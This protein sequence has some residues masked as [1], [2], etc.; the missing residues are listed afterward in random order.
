MLR[1][2]ALAIALQLV[3]PASIVI[4]LWRRQPTGRVDWLMNVLGVLSIVVALAVIAPWLMVPWQLGYGYIAGALAAGA[5][6]FQSARGIEPRHQRGGDI[7]RVGAGLIAAVAVGSSGFAMAGRYLPGTEVVDVTCPFTSGVYLVVNGGSQSLV[8]AHMATLE[9]RPR[10][11]PWRGQSYGVDLVRI[12]G[13]G[14]RA[15]GF[16]SED[17]TDYFIHGQ[18]V[19]APCGGTVLSAVSDRPDMPAGTRD[20]DRSKLAGNHVLISCNGAE[21]LVAHLLRGSVRVGIGSDVK[22]GDPLGLVG[23]SGNTDEPHVHLSAQRRSE[24]QALIGGLPVWLRID[25]RFLVRN[26]RLFCGA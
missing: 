15:S 20:S 13:F 21:V 8:N 12:D 18:P 22:V 17:P 24:G 26:D 7:R 4:W 11:A 23:N 2:A 9:A 1:T 25:G 16:L 5:H 10:F 14:R 6:S 19:I 3:L